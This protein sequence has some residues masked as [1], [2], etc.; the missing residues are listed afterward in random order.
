[1]NRKDIVTLIVTVAA[2]GLTVAAT[3]LPDNIKEQ[4]SWIWQALVA[5][6]GLSI[7]IIIVLI[8]PVRI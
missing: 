7:C 5:G 1:M 6:V 4:Q 8:I 3:L 2:A